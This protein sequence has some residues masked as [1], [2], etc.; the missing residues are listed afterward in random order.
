M[1]KELNKGQ[2][3]EEILR[4]YFL[5]S[6]YFIERGVPFK[7]RDFDVTDIDLWMYNRPSSVSREISIV[8]IKNKKTPQAIERIFWIKGLQSAVKATNALIVTTEKRPDVR[9]F[10]KQ[11]DVFVINGEFLEKIRKFEQFLESRITNEDLQ[12]MIADY[13]LEKLDGDWK[14]KLSE[15]KSLLANGLNFDN[16]NRLIETARFFAHQVLTKPSRKELALRCFYKICSYIAVNIDYIQR[17]LSFFEDNNARRRAFIE[18]FRYGTGG[19]K[20]IRKIIDMSLS[21]VEQYSNNGKTTANQV[22]FKIKE[23][24]ENTKV[25]ILADY[26]SKHDVLK[27]TFS[28]SL[29]FENMAMQ[30]RFA[31]HNESSVEVKSFIAVLLD[32]YSVDRVSFAKISNE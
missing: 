4:I 14:G 5:K 10:G 27:G 23:D 28:A 2:Q 15:S 6:G 8:D 20:N 32:Y 26:F 11:M 19:E 24:F 29:Q 9:D 31:S 13:S 17:D 1:K 25:N 30:K 21:F 22:R 7:Y 16:V 12:T 18:G 3:L